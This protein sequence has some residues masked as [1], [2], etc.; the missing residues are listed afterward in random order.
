MSQKRE[1]AVS[2]VGM[3]SDKNIGLMLGM[4]HY[5]V[6]E[7]RLSEL[8][9]GNSLIKASIQKMF[10]NGLNVEEIFAITHGINRKFIRAFN[11]N[12]VNN[13]PTKKSKLTSKDWSQEQDDRLGKNIDRIIAD[14]LGRTTSEVCERR[15]VKQIPYYN[16]KN[17]EWS[18]AE[19]AVVGTDSDENIAKM[20][21]M[22]KTSINRRR[23][24]LQ[25]PTYRA[26]RPTE[27]SQRTV[28][29]VDTVGLSI[30]ASDKAVETAMNIYTSAQHAPKKYVWVND[31]VKLLGGETDEVVAK[32]L[33]M[34]VE[35]VI[36]KRTDMDILEFVPKKFNQAQIE[37]I[38]NTKHKTHDI[39]NILQI[40]NATVLI[41]RK[42]KTK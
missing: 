17:R 39:A 16:S 37:L 5:Q 19:D 23:T 18:P 13:A 20:L 2:H 25:L 7:V 26:D 40:A 33:N 10:E 11:T 32:L 35:D 8:R 34:T 21:N 36:I 12:G 3:L 28:N 1:E 4:S 30:D 41:H 22:T 6:A 31:S 14:E 15:K 42:L 29:V 38:H 9:S 24:F 27:T